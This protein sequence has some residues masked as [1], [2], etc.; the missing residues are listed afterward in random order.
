MWNGP[1][2]VVNFAPF[3]SVFG[4]QHFTK[5][6]VLLTIVQCTKCVVMVTITMRKSV[7]YSASG[8]LNRFLLSLSLYFRLVRVTYVNLD[9][10]AKKTDRRLDINDFT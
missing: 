6:A 7:Q 10:I 1:P 8:K 2:R 4:K 3:V 9:F 5:K